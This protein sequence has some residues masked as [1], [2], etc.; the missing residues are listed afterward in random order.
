MIFFREQRILGDGRRTILS[1]IKK[2]YLF[3][4]IAKILD[5]CQWEGEP[6]ASGGSDAMPTLASNCTADSSLFLQDV[7][8][9]THDPIL[10]PGEFERHWEE[11]LSEQD[12][13]RKKQ[14]RDN[15]ILYHQRLVR[16]IA[17]RFLGSGES[18]EDL[19]QVGN[20]GLI[21]ALDRFDPS[22]G[23]RFSTYAT[24]T[25][26]GEIRRYFR[27]KSQG[28]KV[29]RWMQE[30]SH[31]LRQQTILLTSEL[32][33]PPKPIELAVRL[34]VTEEEIIQV[35]ASVEATNIASLDSNLNSNTLQEAVTLSDLLGQK[36]KHLFE[37]DEFSDLRSAL[38]GLT[39]R[40][41][42]VIW[43]RFFEDQ[44]QVHIAQHLNISQ[45]HVSRLQKRAL[46]RLKE[47]LSDEPLPKT[48][49]RIRR[50]ISPLE[51]PLEIVEVS[52]VVTIEA[53]STSH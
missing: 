22:Q 23:N 24:P 20:I 27:D 32:G 6:N 16:S 5:S 21:N 28:I 8:I 45:M 33:R 49:R 34:K 40:E 18:L 36:D 19:I 53:E 35:I 50:K 12:F 44:S 52:E 2:Q 31:S 41:R 38:K 47:L 37:V 11:Y 51:I 48:R 14:L 4:K 7:R 29:P 42:E 46:K 1:E 15:W 30:M 9:S 43:M 3:T 26:L 10:P 17:S 25:I 13:E 39:S